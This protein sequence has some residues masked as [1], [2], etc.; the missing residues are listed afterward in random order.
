MVASAA[1]MGSRVLGLLREVLLAAVF[2]ASREYDAFLMAFRIPNLLRDLFAEGALSQAFVKVFT[3]TAAREGDAAAFRVANRVLGLLLVVLGTLTVLGM[4]FSDQVVALVAPG[5]AQVGGK[6]DL[7]SGLTRV[8][9]P[10]ILLVAVAALA[11][12]MLNAKG[13]FGLPQSASSFF[14][15]GS[16]VVGLGTAWALAPGF[17]GTGLRMA[18]GLPASAEAGPHG[19]E[20]AMLGMAVGVLVGGSLQ[21]LVQVPSLWRLGFR[22]RPEIQVTDPRVREVLRLMV[23]TMIGA[24]AVQVNV[25]L[26]NS[27][28]ASYLGD[29][30]ISWLNYA[31]HFMHFP[32]GLFG[33]AIASAAMPE[34]VRART[35]GDMEGLRRAIREALGL[36]TLLCVPAAVGLAVMGEPIIGLVYEHGRFTAGDTAATAAALSAYAAGLAGYAGI[37]VL[38]P[39]LLSLD[40]AKT[41]MFVALGSILVNLVA[42]LVMV[43]VLGWGHVGLALSTSAVALVNCAVLAVV[44]RRR[45]GGMEGRLLLGTILRVVAAAAVMGGAAW[46]A[47][48]ASQHLLP[49]RGAGPRALQLVLGVGTGVLV[50]GALVAALKVRE[51]NLVLEVLRRRKARKAT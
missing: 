36:A 7:T 39:A 13:S 50:Y 9:F 48:R 22:P 25:V 24:A 28:F 47:S 12:G 45:A 1:V 51:V 18:V 41:P 26:V 42:N 8:M 34:F 16:I 43:K 23:P 44:L 31:F 6:L 11:M 40:D 38:Q 14:N 33:V 10:F 20:R 4:V 21:M 32:I 3:Q 29:K 5:F 15:L 19:A 2:G 49:G 46:L 17:V 37:K 35:T 27:N 30:P